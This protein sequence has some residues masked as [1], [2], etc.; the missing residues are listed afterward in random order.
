[1]TRWL[2]LFLVLLPCAAAAQSARTVALAANDLV[3]D[4]LR[5]VVYASVPSSAG[6]L[7]NTITV[8]QPSTGA[9]GPSVFVGSEPGR[10]A[11]SD[12]GQ[13]LYVALGGAPAIRR[14]DLQ[15]FTATQQISLG[16]DP[17]F[18]P[19]YAEDIEVA[20]G[21]PLVIA[22]SLKRAAVSPRHGGVALFSNGVQLPAKTADHTGANVIEYSASAGRLYGYNNETTEFGFRRMDAGPN[23]VSVV[24]VSPG[25]VGSFNADIVFDSGR[26]FSTTG[27]VIDPEARTVVGSFTGVAQAGFPAHVRPAVDRNLVYF[28]SGAVLRAYDA[29]TFVPAG[30]SYTVPGALGNPRTLIRVGVSELA[31]ATSGGQVVFVDPGGSAPPPPPPPPPPPS[32]IAVTLGLGGCS[33]C[34]PGS[35][36]LVTGQLSNGGAAPVPVV[37]KAGLGFPDGR[38]LAVST[39][40]RR[41]FEV[42]LPAGLNVPLEFFRILMPAGVPS[43]TWT[44]EV[45]VLSPELG[46]TYARNVVSFVVP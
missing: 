1:M 39:L 19:Y 12:D 9:L 35:T 45:T 30:S 15:T 4:P 7:G 20:P 44:Y 21:Q 27:A 33:T 38:E 5:Q 34:V 22:A 13:F 24:D 16:S 32:P 37:I 3:Y 2:A 40:G 46:R 29:T 31:F 42:T 41:D 26:I 10:L 8:V 23:G 17:F 6:A 36:L 43:G 11:L 18:G 14:V 28:L 25:L